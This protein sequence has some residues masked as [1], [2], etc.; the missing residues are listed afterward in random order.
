MFNV[1]IGR[2]YHYCLSLIAVYVG[3]E[4]TFA[5]V[6]FS[7]CSHDT[8]CTNLDV[9]PEPEPPQIAQEPWEVSAI[10]LAIALH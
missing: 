4:L 5:C 9:D 6:C 1:E 2:S 8:W 7:T 10:G 3:K